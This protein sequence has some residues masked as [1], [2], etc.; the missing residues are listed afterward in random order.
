MSNIADGDP[1]A[2]PRTIL[3]DSAQL[4]SGEALKGDFKSAAAAEIG[5]FKAQY[6]L[7]HPGAD[8]DKI[9]DE[10]I[11]REV[12]NTVGKPGLLGAEVRCVISVSMLTEGWDANTVSHILGVRVR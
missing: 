6:R 5:A 1:L 3:I 10:D 12:M 11:L 4:E 9:T 8:T 7:T 2:R